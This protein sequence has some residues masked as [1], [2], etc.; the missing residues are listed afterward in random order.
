MG[1]WS[2]TTGLL[3]ALCALIACGSAC[4][5]SSEP[6]I[7]GQ[8]GDGT[9][10]DHSAA[11]GDDSREPERDAG[12]GTASTPNAGAGGS[13][14]GAAGA[15]AD[16]AAATPPDAAVRDAAANDAGSTATDA[17]VEDTA[18]PPNPDPP[19]DTGTPEVDTGTPPDC[20]CV[21]PHQLLPQLNQPRDA[22]C[23]LVACATADCAPEP[24][25]T[26]VA[27]D[28][29]GY[30]ICDSD[31]TWADAKAHCDDSGET[32]LASV[33][34][35]EEDN[36]L[37]GKLADKTWIGGNDLREEGEF[38]WQNGD[39]FWR[40]GAALS[41]GGGPG[42]GPG[43]GGEWEGGGPVDNAYANFLSY[44]PNDQGLNAN[45][46]DCVMLWPQE[47]AWADANCDD[48]HGYV[49]EFALP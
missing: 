20:P 17:K 35:Q 10:E 31:H 19:P 43:G 4:S 34:S 11:A 47:A 38:R 3:L 49:C 21:C 16:A 30:Y 2:R 40:G 33:D 29:S 15:Q 41:G 6:L 23:Q 7:A 9:D 14:Q 36:F 37:L 22:S 39:V 1:G 26:M 45:P 5:F 32:Y 27:L 48:Q 46:G 25:C 18:T 13:G 42:P 28:K 8:H 12:A 24:D 44:E